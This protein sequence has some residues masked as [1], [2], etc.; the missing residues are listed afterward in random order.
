MNDLIVKV[1]HYM[2]KFPEK[3]C[4]LREIREKKLILYMSSEDM[5]FQNIKF[6]KFNFN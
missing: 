3:F 5:F 1:L 2:Q 6:I 4:K